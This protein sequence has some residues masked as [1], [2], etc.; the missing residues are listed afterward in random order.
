MIENKLI[1][2]EILQLLLNNL[3]TCEVL[4]RVPEGCLIFSPNFVKNGYSVI[5]FILSS[6]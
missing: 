6:L 3:I 1:E 2:N 5:D 4:F